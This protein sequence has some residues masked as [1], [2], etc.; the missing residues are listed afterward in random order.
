M[1]NWPIFE[2]QIHEQIR[3]IINKKYNTI[4]EKIERMKKTKTI[5]NQDR[6]HNDNKQDNKITNLTNVKLTR[7][8]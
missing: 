1:K 8:E 6:Q 4:N 3:H 5:V 2:N 7:N